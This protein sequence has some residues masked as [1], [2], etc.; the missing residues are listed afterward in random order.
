MVGFG[1]VLQA[2]ANLEAN[3]LKTAIESR[4]LG[5]NSTLERKG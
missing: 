2:V 3:R 5:N 4:D 1:P